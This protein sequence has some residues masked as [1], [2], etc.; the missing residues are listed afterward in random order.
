MPGTYSLTA[1]SPDEEVAINALLGRKGLPRPDAVLLVLDATAIERSLYLLLQV[2]EFGLPVIA[3]V[4]ML[5]A[6]RDDGVDIHFDALRRS[7]GV[8][9]VGTIARRRQGINL[10]REQLDD[11]LTGLPERQVRS[12][13][14][15]PR[16]S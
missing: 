16:P 2:I 5:D 9:V 4:N 15:S 12:G 14:G 13:S 11:L 3:V 10:V 1:R 6:A 7:L 8:P